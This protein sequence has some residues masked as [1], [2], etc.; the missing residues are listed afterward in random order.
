MASM[1]SGVAIIDILEVLDPRRSKSSREA[2]TMVLMVP[3]DLLN[4]LAISLILKPSLKKAFLILLNSSIRIILS[5]ID[6]CLL[7]MIDRV[8]EDWI[9]WIQCLLSTLI[10]TP[11][12]FGCDT[13]QFYFATNSLLL[14]LCGEKNK[15]M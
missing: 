3:Q 11:L 5:C 13:P 12:N 1:T 15:I 9:F 10:A 14:S 2:L 6:F 7:A 8:F 4:F